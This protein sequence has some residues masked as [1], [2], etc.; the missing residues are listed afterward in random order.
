MSR[1]V[2]AY[3]FLYVAPPNIDFSQPSHSAKVQLFFSYFII[4]ITFSEKFLRL[5]T[6]HL[7]IRFIEL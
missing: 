1:R 3:G 2:T 5:K 4:F 6:S 7:T